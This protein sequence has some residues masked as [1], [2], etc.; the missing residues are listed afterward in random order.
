M[1]T[2]FS[3]GS[4][5]LGYLYQARYALY[6]ILTSDTEQELAVESLDDITFFDGENNAKELL[7]L[8][9][10]TNHKASLTDSSTDFWKTIRVWS[11]Q[12]KE[13]K[14]LL[15]GTL[16][17]LVSTAEA[18]NNSIASLLR[19][20]GRD[21]RLAAQKMLQVANTSQNKTLV[22]SFEAFKELTDKEQQ[23]L[24]DSIQILDSSFNIIDVKPKIKDR[25][26]GVRREF[27]DSVY[28][29]LEGWWF[30]KIVR[31]LSD[32]SVNLISGFE[33]QDKISEINDQFKPDALPIDFLDLELSNEPELSQDDRRFVLQLKEIA[34]H[35]KRIE[36]AILDYYKAFE[37][38]SKW[39]R[40]ELVMGDEIEK[41]EK[42][43]IDE[44]E[45]YFLMLQ[46]EISEDEENE[47]EL[48][49][50]GR[51]IYNWMEQQADIRIRSK[52]T[53]PYVMRGSY[54]MLA[55]QNPPRVNW[56]PMF[57]ERLTQLLASA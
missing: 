15:P 1:S 57:L 32:H 42:K 48:K 46:E 55:D 16:L 3:A 12:F 22:K 10:H 26:I 27:R 41:Y 35:N 30:S 47:S 5:A 29:R 44:W 6:L 4:Q 52:V 9:H 40:E 18:S 11:T 24:I 50:I 28:E 20:T 23:V 54:H 19:P 49:K 36:K 56:H 8:K 45:R 51:N 25:L 2:E 33:V 21:S 53:E 17:T 37:Q 14:I 38:R 13:K 34:I 7:Q 43:L 31:H 39:L